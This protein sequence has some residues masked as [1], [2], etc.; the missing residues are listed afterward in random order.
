VPSKVAAAADNASPNVENAVF[1]RHLQTV[2]FLP[3]PFA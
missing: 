3:R 2:T 1:E